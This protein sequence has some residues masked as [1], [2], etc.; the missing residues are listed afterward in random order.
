MGD[1]SH[2]GQGSVLLDIGGNVGALIVSMPPT[3]LG[4]EIEIR[5]AGVRTAVPA[6]HDHGHGGDHHHLPHVAVL[7]RPRD[8]SAG[9]PVASAVFA[10]LEEGDYELYVRPDGAVQ[11]SATVRGGE[12]TF[13]AWPSDTAL[14]SEHAGG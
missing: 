5:P 8:G 14:D 10:E 7:N 3:L 6:P 9:P 12:V 13:A 11:L 4:A 1:N 2:A